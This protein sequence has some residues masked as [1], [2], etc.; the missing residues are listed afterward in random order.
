MS[1]KSARTICL[2]FVYSITAQRT[3][4]VNCSLHNTHIEERYLNFNHTHDSPREC[5]KHIILT[6]WHFL[7]DWTFVPSIFLVYST[8]YIMAI[9][10]V[11]FG[12]LYSGWL[13]GCLKWDASLVD[14][15][16]TWLDNLMFCIQNS[17]GTWILD[18]LVFSA[19]FQ[20]HCF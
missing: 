12:T 11:S 6:R 10:K 8:K 16:S 15:C 13:A 7:A 9:L 3:F 4:D 20:C 5:M 14:R 17:A 2:P 18:Y 1:K 19:Y